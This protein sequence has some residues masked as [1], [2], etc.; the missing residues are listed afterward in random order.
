MLEE[1][2]I[3]D[4]IFLEHL[5]VELGFLWDVFTLRRCSKIL[6]ELMTVGIE[7]FGYQKK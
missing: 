2:R 5:S 7:S 3:D 6:R 4:L 1:V